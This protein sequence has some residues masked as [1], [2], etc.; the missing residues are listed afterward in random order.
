MGQKFFAPVNNPK[1]YGIATIKNKKIISLKEKP[2]TT[3]SNL[4]ITGLYFFDK[5]VVSLSKTLKLSKEKN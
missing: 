1:Q 3:I 2:V 5:K 4:A